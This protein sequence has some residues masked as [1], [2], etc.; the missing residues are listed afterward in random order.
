MLCYHA[1]K[2]S[3]KI[4][5]TDGDILIVNLTAALTIVVIIVLNLYVTPY[6]GVIFQNMNH[7]DFSE[8]KDLV[9]I[10]RRLQ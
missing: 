6:V 4:H 3:Q 10:L 2:L 1:V 5:E 7:A 8:W 9:Q